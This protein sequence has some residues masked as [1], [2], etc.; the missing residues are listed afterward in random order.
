MTVR[1][2]A[3]QGIMRAIKELESVVGILVIANPMSDELPMVKDMRATS[4]KMMDWVR[5]VAKLKGIT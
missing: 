5:D 3:Q 1:A 2:D 4:K